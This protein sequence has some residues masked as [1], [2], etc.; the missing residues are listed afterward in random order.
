MLDANPVLDIK[1]PKLGKR[2]PHVLDVDQTAQILDI[3]Q[4]AERDPHAI[5]D[6]AIMELL[7]SSAL[8]VT[9]LVQLDCEDLDMSGGEVRV[10]GKGSK[11][12]R[13]FRHPCATHLLEAAGDIRYVQEF[14]GHSSISTTAIYTHLGAAH[15]LACSA[16]EA[17]I[18]G[19]PGARW[20]LLPRGDATAERYQRLSQ[21]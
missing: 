6:K 3:A 19:L 8:R 11:D 15:Q 18:E 10:L 12:P 1:A 7:Y 9:E 5:R 16:Y 21:S 2:L 14:L 20:L 17:F 4:Y 13:V